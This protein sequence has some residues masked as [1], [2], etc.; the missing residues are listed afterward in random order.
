MRLIALL[1]GLVPFMAFAE[2]KIALIIDDIGYHKSDIKALSLPDAVTLS[3][4]PH[5]PYGERLA[6]EAKQPIMLH[7]PMEPISTHVHLEKDT[8]T[9]EQN[10]QQME[11]LLN[12]ALKAI[13][14]A[15]GVNN[16]MGSLLTEDRTRMDWLMAM[17]SKRGLY[18]VDSRTT[19]KSQALLAAQ[20]AGVPAVS[21]RI[22]LDNSASVLNHQWQRALE[23]AHKLGHVV[24]IAHPHPTTLA[25]L[26]K[27]LSNM[28]DV[29]L[30]PVSSLM[31]KE[32]LASSGKMAANRG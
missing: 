17:L 15:K 2:P 19:A 9:V 3:V 7:M 1:F 18:F 26:S 23:I 24:V 29:E 22:F 30:V 32:Q 13:P 28:K 11:A 16:H 5:T 4:L 14:Q 10:R 21:R 31:P 25:F 12:D 6:A 8:M 27:A 20:A